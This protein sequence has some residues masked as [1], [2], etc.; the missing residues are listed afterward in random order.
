MQGREFLY[1]A[2]RNLYFDGPWVL[3]FLQGF[4]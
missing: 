2:I 1:D 3:F 4:F